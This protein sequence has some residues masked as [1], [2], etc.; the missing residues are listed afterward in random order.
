[1]G[2][3]LLLVAALASCGSPA[4]HY[5]YANSKGAALYGR[6]R[7]TGQ[8]IRIKAVTARSYYVGLETSMPAVPGFKP[9]IK[10]LCV[11]PQGMEEGSALLIDERVSG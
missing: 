4:T 3:R 2:S 5:D 1:M 11:V 9:P 6:N 10:A 8:G 7:V